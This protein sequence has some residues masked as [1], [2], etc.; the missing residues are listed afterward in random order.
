MILAESGKIPLTDPEIICRRSQV[1]QQ[2]FVRKM[3]KCITKH[4]YTSMLAPQI[5]A[6]SFR[7]I[8]TYF[9]DGHALYTA[10]PHQV[11]SSSDS[12]V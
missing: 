10:F 1:L 7:S 11:L 3:V 8:Y 4:T 9:Y 2:Y 12:F 6:S 5:S